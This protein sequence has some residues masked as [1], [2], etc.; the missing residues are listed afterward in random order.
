M[1]GYPLILADSLLVRLLTMTAVSP[2]STVTSEANCWLLRIGMLFT[3]PP[4]SASIFR[5]R[6][7]LM[8]PERCTTGVAFKVRPRSSY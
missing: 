6:C 1:P 8:A 5:S 3:A 4:V 2:S 7:I